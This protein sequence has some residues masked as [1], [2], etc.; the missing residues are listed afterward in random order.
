M[1][2]T[3]RKATIV[4]IAKALGTSIATVHRALHNHPNIR[5]ATKNRVLKMAKKLDYKPNLAARY[6]SSKRTLRI[7]INT[8]QGK[9]SF[10]DEV[11]AGIEEETKFLDLENVELKFRTYPYL[12]KSEEVA[13]DSALEAGV[14][15][16]V[17][18]PSSPQNLKKF[19]QQSKAKDVPLVFVATDAPGVP[20]LTV[21]SI[22]TKASGFLAADL[23]GR[24]L[25]GK[26]RV[27]LTMFDTKITEHAEKG[28]AFVRTLNR[29]YPAICA[30]DPIEDHDV[31]SEA[32]EKTCRLIAAH[33]DL[34]GIYVTTEVSIPVIKAARDLGVL[35]RLTIVT[36]DLF[37]SLV[38][39]IKAGTVAATIYQRPRT[40]GR[41]AFR[42]LYEFLV[43]GSRP[44][45][46]ITL[47]PHLVMRGNA[48]SVLGQDPSDINEDG[49]DE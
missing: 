28:E 6:L 5:P 9:T 4:D 20:R 26:G 46:R 45:R 24:L 47:A 29:Y 33:P 8:L 35:D 13:L 21:V 38:K 41:M 31:E 39:E 48:D 42:A 22:D 11:R 15:G 25:G 12:G 2:E 10:W 17:A 16:I 34:A 23:M 27:A 40:Q 3:T 44:P 14:D 19:M 30:E 43:D 37:P 36:T 18:F 7:S 1:T 32:Y 49:L